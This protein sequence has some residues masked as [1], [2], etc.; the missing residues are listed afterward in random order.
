MA[1]V[2]LVIEPY[3]GGSNKQLLDTILEGKYIW[4]TIYNEK[5]DKFFV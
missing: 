1:P 4:G 3:F 2:I 5:K